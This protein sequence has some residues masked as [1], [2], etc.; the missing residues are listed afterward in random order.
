MS[1]HRGDVHGKFLD[2]EMEDIR[3]CALAWLR[4]TDRH[5][6]LDSIVFDLDLDQGRSVQVRTDLE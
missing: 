6:D 3:I 4:D 2:L 5:R 1:Y